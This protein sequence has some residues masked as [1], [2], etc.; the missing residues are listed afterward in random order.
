MRVGPRRARE[1]RAR[2]RRGRRRVYTKI[3]GGLLALAQAPDARLGDLQPQPAAGAFS[4]SILRLDNTQRIGELRPEP[5][6]LQDIVGDG[7]G[8]WA[9]APGG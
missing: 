7:R 1:L 8:L 4:A 5:R 6:V 3:G 2:A 9:L